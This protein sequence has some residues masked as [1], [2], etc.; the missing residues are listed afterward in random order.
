MTRSFTYSRDEVDDVK[1]ERISTAE[2]PKLEGENDLAYINRLFA[3]AVRERRLELGLTQK[4][5]AQKTRAQLQLIE[6]LERGEL[7][8]QIFLVGKIMDALK[9]G[10]VARHK[11]EDDFF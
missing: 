4:Q 10:I 9:L 2:F 11:N 1:G 8:P 7:N 3:Q 5:L 6:R